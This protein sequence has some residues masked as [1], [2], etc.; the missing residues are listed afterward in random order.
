M[1]TTDKLERLI[2]A[3]IKSGCHKYDAIF[4]GDV[5]AEAM[6]LMEL[7]KE[8]RGY[9]AKPAYRFVDTSLQTLRRRGVIEYSRSL[10]WRVK[11]ST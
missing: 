8:A 4:F 9:N 11:E 10:G 3:A 6:R 1:R 2:V 5:K 7:D